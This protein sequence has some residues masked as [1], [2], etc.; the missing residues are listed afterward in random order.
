MG[1]MLSQEEINALLNGSPPLDDEADGGASG[2]KSAIRG[3]DSG[4]TFENTNYSDMLSAEQKDILGEFGNISMGTAATTLSTL[5]A[6]K[7]N[8]DTPSVKIMTWDD[9]KSRYERPFVGIRVDY[10]VGLR[11]SN[12]MALQMHDVKI[13][14]N[15]MMGGDG[16]VEGPVEI[17]EIDLSAIGEAMNQMVGSSSTSISSMIKTKIDIDTPKAFVIDFS[18]EEF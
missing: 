4:N 10:R 17:N 6:N 9:L 14:S 8:I 5:L 12:I 15:L 16:T 7:V 1:D 18:D 2:S 13:I 3:F 11:G